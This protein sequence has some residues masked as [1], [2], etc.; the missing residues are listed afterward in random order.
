MMPT[1]VPGPHN[2]LSDTYGVSNPSPSPT[3][4]F[5]TG[6]TIPGMLRMGNL[7]IHDRPRVPF[8]DPQ[9]GER[10]I[11]TVH[12][13]SFNLPD[14]VA[15]HYHLPHGTSVLLP[16]VFWNADHKGGYVEQDMH[17]VFQHFL[18]TGENLGFF[19]DNAS[20]DTYSKSLHEQQAQEFNPQGGP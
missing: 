19:K 8:T 6:G 18:Q 3:P 10:S 2:S 20:A 7:N 15:D 16:S 13:G 12:S 5:S 9:S 17:K 11:A 1:D 14:E 4:A